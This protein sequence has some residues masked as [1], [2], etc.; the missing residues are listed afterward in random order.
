[1]V[2]K[3]SEGLSYYSIQKTLI[4][5]IKRSIF[6]HVEKLKTLNVKISTALWKELILEEKEAL[7]K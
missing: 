5:S 3:L 6:D 2:T 4:T 1:M 7:A